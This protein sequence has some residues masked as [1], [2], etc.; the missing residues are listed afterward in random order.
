MAEFPILDPTYL[1]MLCDVFGGLDDLITDNEIRAL[2]AAS[3]VEDVI[4]N[5][6]RRKRLLQ[7]FVSSQEKDGSFDSIALFLKRTGFHIER[8]KGPDS[9]KRYHEEINAVLVYA[10]LCLGSD[11]KPTPLERDDKDDTPAGA[12]DRLRALVNALKNRQVHPD[13]VHVFK[14]EY[15][16]DDNY[17]RPVR[18]AAWMLAAK[19]ARK[20]GLHTE[21]PEI[22]EQ[23]FN[24][25]YQGAYP[26]LAINRLSTEAEVGEQYAFM[27]LLKATLLTF[28][29]E[30]TRAYRA[31]W[32][33]TKD[34]ALDFLALLSLLH[35]KVDQAMRLA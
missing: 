31:P 5:A 13:L 12:D 22:A 34:E 9:I 26:I 23:A 10:G 16:A 6:T 30:Y 28:Q 25:Q 11:H 4:P 21:G 2:L 32:M 35:K 15:F 18:E 3:D 27:C 7:A 8:T 20:A 33:V 14:V 1:T 17:F 29:D 24:A 19:V